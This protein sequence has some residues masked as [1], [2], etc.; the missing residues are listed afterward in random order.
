MLDYLFQR[1]TAEVA[2]VAQAKDDAWETCLR[3]E[4]SPVMLQ[5]GGAA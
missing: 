1:L 5:K 4:P 3:P 2:T